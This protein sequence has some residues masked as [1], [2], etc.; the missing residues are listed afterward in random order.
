MV[1]EKVE[2]CPYTPMTKARFENPV[3]TSLRSL[4]GLQIRRKQ[5]PWTISSTLEKRSG[6]KK[7]V[8]YVSNKEIIVVEAKI[9]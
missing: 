4:I 1:L 6:L 3:H 8:R 9:P 7:Y 5:N 2:R